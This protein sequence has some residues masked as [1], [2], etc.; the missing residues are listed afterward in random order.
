MAVAI[1]AAIGAQIQYL[2][3]HDLFKPVNFFSFFTID[4][5]VLAVLTLLGLEF[6]ASTA[7]GRFARWARGGT[8]LYMTMTGIIYAV[9]L[10]PI[11]AD[12]STQLDW[13]N[14]VVHVIG[15]IVVLADW[16]LW[17]P[18]RA[19]SIREAACWLVF[20]IVWLA[21]S[22]VRGSIV[23]WYPYPFM[24][25]RDGVEHAAGS[26]AAV[27]TTIAV[28]TVFVIVLALAIRWLT[29]KRVAAS[30]AAVD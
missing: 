6:G 13:V 29:T 14:S 9:L 30:P 26:W 10:A 7:P 5:N 2:V 21:Y 3:V 17:P 15:P 18:D 19:P 20:P 28:L 27:G 25:P 12:V 23:D 4:S 1:V 8:T 22:I 16:F 24:D 11:S